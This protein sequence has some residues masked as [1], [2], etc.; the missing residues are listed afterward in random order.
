MDILRLLEIYVF[1]SVFH[2]FS[3]N[4]VYDSKFGQLFINIR[5][6]KSIISAEKKKT[7]LSFIFKLY[8]PALLSSTEDAGAKA[9]IFALPVGRFLTD[10]GTCA[11]SK[12]SLEGDG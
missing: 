9:R 10:K 2:Y 8:G 4:L 3:R 12:P 7:Y 5:F 11:Y 1:S 6:A